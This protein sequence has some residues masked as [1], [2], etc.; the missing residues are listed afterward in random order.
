[1]LMRVSS[2]DVLIIANSCSLAVSNGVDMLR[3]LDSDLL[4]TYVSLI[5]FVLSEFLMA[6]LMG[7]H[8][9]RF[10]CF[11]FCFSFYSNQLDNAS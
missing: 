6:Y 8:R 10:G 3:S 7:I 1:M 4:L 11:L 2:N 9:N 5:I